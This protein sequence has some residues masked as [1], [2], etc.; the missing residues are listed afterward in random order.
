MVLLERTARQESPGKTVNRVRTDPKVSQELLESQV[1]ME[2]EGHQENQ[3][4]RKTA[5]MVL[6]D[7]QGLLDHLDHQA[8]HTFL[9]RGIKAPLES[10][11]R[12]ESLEP[13][14]SPD[15]QDLLGK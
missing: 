11:V 7:H 14:A 8:R 15:L 4:P 12:M 13:Q 5:K 6:K 3:C 1:K 2:Q 10:P 9:E